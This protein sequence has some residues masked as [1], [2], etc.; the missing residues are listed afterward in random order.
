MNIRLPRRLR[1][2]LVAL[3][4]L[5]VA[6]GCASAPTSL[7][8]FGGAAYLAV[9]LDLSGANHRPGSPS[10]LAALS[11][12][13]E[14]AFLLSCGELAGSDCLVEG[15]W[16]VDRGAH[17]F[18]YEFKNS[19]AMP[20]TVT[21]AIL[22]EPGLPARLDVEFVDDQAIACV[23][24]ALTGPAIRHGPLAAMRFASRRTHVAGMYA[25]SISLAA[26]Q[27]TG[28]PVWRVERTQESEKVRYISVVDAVTGEVLDER[29][30]TIES[31]GRRLDEAL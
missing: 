3:P 18:R 24:G 29:R 5:L 14:C 30:S 26:D 12:A 31:R 21:I 28:H 2:W 15:R 23:N 4:C 6:P 19:D 10:H 25:T 20:Y 17:W 13:D 8:L 7:L 16:N 27:E 1:P 9:G 22:A 11:A